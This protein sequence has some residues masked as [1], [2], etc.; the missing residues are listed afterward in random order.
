MLH[1]AAFILDGN[2][3]FCVFLHDGVEARH[4]G[5]T[6]LEKLVIRDAFCEVFIALQQVANVGREPFVFVYAVRSLFGGNVEV[7]LFCYCGIVFVLGDDAVGEHAGKNH[8]AALNG[9]FRIGDGIVQRGRVRDADKRRRLRDGQF[10]GV[11]RIIMLGSGLDAV[12][13]I[14]VIDGVEVHEKNLV[15][16]VD[17]LEF[18]GEIDF[19]HLALDRDV[20]HLV[21][22]DGVAHVLL[23][24][25]RGSL[26][27][28]C[29]V[30]EKG[31]HDALQVDAFML[32]ETNVFGG[33]GSLGNVGSYF[34]KRRER[35]AFFQVKLRQDSARAGGRVIIVGVD[36]RLLGKLEGI[37]VVDVWQVFAPFVDKRHS[38]LIA[39][40]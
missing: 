40:E 9:G 25:S 3:F 12:A 2:G 33:D 29:Q 21:G 23:R 15:F 4:D 34:V 26:L 35:L 28:S 16:R 39:T 32:V 18:D 22:D 5:E 27:A 13:A 6:A 20:G 7:E 10:V 38:A 8:V 14:A 24:N 17:L 30:Y 1:R 37:R 19:A 11:L 31:S 36:R